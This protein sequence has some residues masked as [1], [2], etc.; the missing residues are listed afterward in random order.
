MLNPGS[1]V[2]QLGVARLL[3][4]DALERAFQLGAASIDVNGAV[5]SAAG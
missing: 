1:R 5:D 4:E 3:G 2:L